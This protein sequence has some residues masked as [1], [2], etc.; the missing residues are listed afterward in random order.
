MSDDAEAE[1]YADAQ[2]AWATVTGKG[3]D[4]YVC[5]PAS[6]GGGEMVGEVWDDSDPVEMK[7]RLPRLVEKY[8]S[9]NGW[10]NG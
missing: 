1:I 7:R 10:S 8:G 6:P 3:M 9:T 5:P 4:E 2:R